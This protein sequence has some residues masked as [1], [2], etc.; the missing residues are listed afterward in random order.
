MRNQFKS[1]NPGMTF[2]Q[3]SK[4]TSQMYKAITPKLKYVWGQQALKDK[5]RYGIEIAQYFLP[6]GYDTK[7]NIVVS[8]L[9]A[10]K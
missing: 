10:K 5:T 4:Y 8:A 3:L 9:I 2:G 6:P 1:D 7:R